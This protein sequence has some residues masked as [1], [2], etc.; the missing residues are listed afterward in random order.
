MDQQKSWISYI[1]TMHHEKGTNI[2]YVMTRIPRLRVCPVIQIKS[3]HSTVS[4]MKSGCWEKATFIHSFL[5]TQE[6]AAVNSATAARPN[7]QVG[8]MTVILIKSCRE[9]NLRDFEGTKYRCSWL[10]IADEGKKLGIGP[11][12]HNALGGRRRRRCLGCKAYAA[13]SEII[14]DSYFPEYATFREKLYDRADH[15]ISTKWSMVCEGEHFE[16]FK[17]GTGLG[18]HE[19]WNKIR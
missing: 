3:P 13:S 18:M 8:K 5:F 9:E 14:S 17:L 16:A 6:M 11:P 2:T 10:S 4:K 19:N 15:P 1:N 12:K 7:S